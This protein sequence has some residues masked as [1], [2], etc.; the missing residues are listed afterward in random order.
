MDQHLFDNLTRAVGSSASRREALKLAGKSVAGSVAAW[1]GVR[2]L[3]FDTALASDSAIAGGTCQPLRE[4]G[5]CPQGTQKQEK[6]GNV[7]SV[8][9]CG[10]QGSSFT[11]PQG[12]G[13]ADF[14]PSCNAHDT[15]YEDCGAT[16]EQCDVRFLGDMLS[17]CNAAYPGF[18]NILYRFACYELASTFY[19]FVSFFGGEF[20]DAGQQKACECCEPEPLF[21]YC[22]CNDTCYDD[23]SVCLNECEVS[24]GCFTGICEPAS[25]EQCPG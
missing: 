24:L 11:P 16:Q 8:N 20:Y 14:T 10:G 12:F 13:D 6:E 7:P 18:G 4:D 3:A 19:D 2:T 25:L 1:L 5:S 23:I 15:C 9:G 21:L 22:N 17:S